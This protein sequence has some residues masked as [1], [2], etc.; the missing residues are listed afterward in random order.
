MNELVAKRYSDASGAPLLTVVVPVYNRAEIVGASLDSI[1]AQDVRPL[2]LIVVDN[3]STD[4]SLEVVRRWA[5]QHSGEG[6]TVDILGEKRPGAAAARNRGLREVETPYMMFFDSDDIM[7]PGHC[8]RVMEAFLGEETPDLVGWDCSLYADGKYM[9]NLVFD[10]AGSH[11][12]NVLFGSMSTQR[13]AARTSVFRRAGEWNETCRGWDDVELGERI[14]PLSP[15]ILKLTGA[16]TVRVNAMAESISG[17]GFLSGRGKWEHAL[18]LM[19]RTA[20]DSTALRRIVNLRRAILAGDY[21]L[22]GGKVESEALMEI[23]LS[24]ERSYF[25]RMLYRFTRR[26]RGAGMRGAARLLRPLFPER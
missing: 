18:D 4:G 8:S 3:N 22:E 14:L 2:R 16:P 23:V 25:Y 21:L 26:Y 15:N 7:L 20:G 1:A 6:L 10:G 11:F 13:Y 24:K 17:I 9:K 5:G 19:E 12:A